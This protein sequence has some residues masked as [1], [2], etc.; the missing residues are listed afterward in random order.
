MDIYIN[1]NF[2]GYH[3]FGIEDVYS[4]KGK[5]PLQESI[6]N[7]KHST[8]IGRLITYDP[9][10]IVLVEDNS[11]LILAIRGI[12]DTRLDTYNRKHLEIAII[13][14]GNRNDFELLH[15]IILTYI[16]HKKEFDAW[17]RST[18][19][20]D[21]S[22]VLFD[23]QL[24]F[25]GLKK[26][27]IANII[28]HKGL[29]NLVYTLGLC[30]VCSNWSTEKISSLLGIDK[31]KVSSSIEKLEHCSAH[32]WI[33]NPFIEEQVSEIEI[34]TSKDEISSSKKQMML[35]VTI[36]LIIGIIIGLIL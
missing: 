6:H 26:I 35:Y 20:S 14:I 2:C 12:E 33:T 16:N 25:K 5:V 7:K 31:R 27:Q 11:E 32:K 13:L 1:Y 22:D 10:D 3:W 36:A 28:K 19:Y 8:L 34:K 23:T 17:L 30:F 15:K 21:I 4:A 18:L 9:Y 29:G 24:F